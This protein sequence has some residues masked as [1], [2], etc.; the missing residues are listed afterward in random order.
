MTQASAGRESYGLALALVLCLTVAP[1]STWAQDSPPGGIEAIHTPSASGVAALLPADRQEVARARRGPREADAVLASYLGS[2]LA[3]RLELATSAGDRPLVALAFGGRGVLPLSERTTILLI[4]GLDGLSLSG[5]E[6]VLAAIDSLLAHPERLPGHVAFVAVPWANP[7][8][9]ERALERGWSD[10]RNDR[11]MDDDGD[12]EI[13]EDGPDDLDGDGAVLDMLVEDREGP[14]ARASDAR[15]LRPARPGEAPRFWRVPEG[16]D[17]DGDGRFNEDPPG[18]VAPDRNFPVGWRASRAVSC[19]GPW[20]V[21]EPETGALVELVQSRRSAVVLLFQGNDGTLSGPGRAIGGEGGLVLPLS[22]DRATFER[23]AQSYARHAQRAFET[24]TH[25]PA[26]HGGAAVDWLYAARG[27][28]ACEIAVWGPQVEAGRVDARAPRDARFEREERA[29]ADVPAA[30]LAWARWL[31]DT[32]GGIGFV[33]WQP[34][35]LGAGRSGWIGGFQPDTCQNPPADA[36]ARALEGVG[37]FV[38]ELATSMP[39][40]SIDVLEMRREGRVCVVRARVQNEGALPSGVGQRGRDHALTLAL[41]LPEGASLLAGEPVREL[42]HLPALGA[43]AEEGWVVSAGEG[44]V[45]RLEAR[46]VWLPTLVRELR[47]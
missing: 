34:V 37:P 38:L 25:V 10:G 23:L 26:A 6:A 5:S 13:D 35:D 9:L 31:D 22:E 11:P 47:P 28:L 41:V 12:G 19:D 40:L 29:H 45:L 33:E 8:A 44:A 36:W 2:G 32:R 21:S 30:D 15:F 27:S 18:G 20:P 43:S 7:D 24:R 17:D 14:W 16:R 42:G 1:V 39:K 4:G 46:S 3:E